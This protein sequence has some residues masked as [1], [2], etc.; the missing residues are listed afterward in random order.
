MIASNTQNTLTIATTDDLSGVVGGELVGVHTFNT[1]TVTG[2]ADVDF[3]EDRVIEA[4]DVAAIIDADGD[5]LS[6]TDEITYGTD[7]FNPDSDGDGI[8]DGLEV[9]LG[10]NPADSASG[11]VSANTI[12]LLVT[13]ATI[14]TDI[15]SQTQPIQLAVVAVVG[16]NSKVYHVDVTN[17]TYPGGA[18]YNSSDT[19]VATSQGDGSFTVVGTGTATLT[20]AFAGYEATSSLTITP[21][22]AVDWSTQTV[23]LTEDRT[24]DS[25]LLNQSTITGQYVLHSLGDLQ[26]QGA[27]V[28]TTINV[29]ELVVDGDLIIDGTTL[30][31]SAVNGINVTG[32]VSLL[33]GAVLTVAE[34][35]SSPAVLHGLELVVGGTLTV[36]AGS[37][38]DLNGRGY[39][40]S[41]WSGPD[42]S[43]NTRRG[44]HG[45][46]RG[47]TSADC[48]YGRYERARYAGSAGNYY[49][50]DNQADGGGVAEITAQSLVLE[51][52]I[53]AN[54][55]ST[56]TRTEGAG[57][58]GGLHVEVDTLSGAGQF[59]V[60]GGGA[61]N[62]SSYP[63]GGGG[64]IS[65][66]VADRSGFSGTYQAATGGSGQPGGAGT[67]YIRDAGQ[68]YGH[69][70]VDN[71]GRTGA[72]GSTPMRVVGR[73][74]ITGAGEVAPGVW[75]LDVSGTPWRATDEALGWGVDG[76]EVDLDASETS[77]PQYEIESNT[78]NT[79]T[80]ATTD[81]LSGVVGS[82]LVGVHT[83]ETLTVAGGADVDFGEDRVVVLDVAG[84]SIGAGSTLRLG[85]VDE[86]T[87]ELGGSGGG[88]L[89]V[90]HNPALSNL[91]LS[92]LGGSTLQFDEP[93]VVDTLSVSSGTVRFN[94]GVEVAGALSLGNAAQVTVLA[95]AAD[96]LVITDGARLTGEAVSVD[97]DISLLNG[98]V[99]TVAE[100]TSSPAV[101]HGLELVVGG[102]LTV[103]AGSVIDLNG[104][105]YPSSHWSGP[106]FSNNTRRGCH[107]GLRGNTS[108]DCSY[109]RYER[110][111]YAGSAGN[112]YNVDNQADGGG[113]AEITAQS[114]VL[115]GV[116]RANGESTWT[117]TEGAG[118]GGGLHVEVDTLSGAGQF[119][120][121]GGG[122]YNSSSY[123]AGGGGR[124][125][126]YVAD[127]SG[128][129][130]TY[131]AATGGS[132]Q[133]GGAGTVYIRDAGQAYGHLVVDNAG[134]TGAS[135]STP[136]RVV[137]RHMITGAGEVAPGVWK[138]DVSG[139][140]WRATDEALG[141]GVDGI[142]VDLDASETSSPQYE[143]ESNTANT[144]TIATTDDLS[145]VVGGELVGV[146]TFETLTV[147]GGADVDFG[148]DRVVV[149]DVAG[150]SI[151]AGSTLRLGEVDQATLE[152][153]GSGGGTLQ[154]RHNPA[155]SNL[156][157]SSL[158]GSTLQ[159]DE[160][161]VVDTL[162][163]SSGTVRF[164]AGVEVAGALSLG[165][166]AQVTALALAAD[167]LVITDG[168]RL[169][170][171]A[172]SV[173]TDV[174]LLNGAVLTV[175]EATSS[176]AVLHGLELVVGGTLTVD[177]GSVID[178]N[179]RG[180]PSSHWSGPDFSNNTRRGCHGGL[181]G[182]TSA[183]CSYGRY[184]RARYAGS[185]G[186]Y[187]NVDNQA[188][189]GGVA[190]ITAQSLV[191]EGV[192][193]A[194]GEST[195]TRTEGAGAGGGLHVEVDTLSGAGQFA[196]RGG[197]AY[198]SSSYPAGGGGRI[199]VY[200]AD[201]SGFSG[202]YQ[203]ATGGSGQPGGAGT[204]YIRD[205]GQAYGHL[206]VDNAGRTGASGSTPM[207]VVG[208]HMI[209]G[210]GEVAPG[211]WKLDVSGT[212]W[213][214]TDEA[215]GWGVDGIEVDL[216]ASETSSPQYEIESNTAN[217]LTIA[218]TDDLSGVVG[219]ELVGVHTFE[220]LTVAGGADMDFGED[221][222][223]VL[224]V[225]GSSIGAGST[226]RLGE[227]DQATLELGGSGGGTLQV[228]HNPALSNLNLSSLGGSTLQFDEPVVVDTLSVSSGTVRF[229]AG[230]EVA[231][232]L[233]L[234]NA[235]QV[236]AL[237]LAADSLVITDGARL[238]GE[239]VSVDT[240]VS[241]LNGAVLTVAEAT[242]SPA[243][244]HGL[245][246]VVGG[247]LTVDAGS[248][249][250]LNG[251]GYPS[252]H[253]SGPDF[254]NNTRRGCH[255]G[256][257][258]NTSAD[259]SYGRYERARYAG[260][261]GNYYNV[262]NQAD[263]GGVAEITAQSLVLEG[264]IRANGES[265]WTRTE[266]AGAGGGLHV[267]VDTLSGA[268]QFAVRGGG[269]YNSSS[270]PAGGGGRISVYVADRSG[271]S[272]TYQAATGGSG[273]PGGA[274]TVYIRDAGQAYG[275]LVVDNAGRTGAS[276]STPMRVVGRHMITGAGEVAPGVWKLDVSGTPWRATDE[277][278][279]W[280]VDGI[281]V[282]LDASETSSPQYEIESNTANTLTIATTD[283]LSGVVGSELVGVHTFETLTVAGGADVDFGEDRVVQLH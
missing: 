226:L 85:E 7:P 230:V 109:G 159:F 243:V 168:A 267:E 262:D 250:D 79:L 245:E 204:V 126:V 219:S 118:A 69:L 143:I 64:R 166:A 10:T 43:N 111:R 13:P 198:N 56:W 92:G 280:G 6:D 68:A 138:L 232:A 277:A 104:R 122:A 101:L 24:I 192:I 102:T 132:G 283:D 259:C 253:W 117:R 194:N 27:G 34:A 108:A 129:S 176:P 134:R 112:Y 145:G 14:T 130:G 136:M 244:L 242:S 110:A 196:V 5:E 51:G 39:P 191:L 251:R 164:N 228:R 184:E 133:P 57:A 212:P 223:V 73:H 144:L 82:E 41:H 182:N 93:V 186:N 36:D 161:V 263:G 150:S 160:P 76:I 22:P 124:I 257:R 32:N 87:L 265:T 153:G 18:T 152:L 208:R 221:R 183:D 205:A 12:A 107:G 48:S 128:F 282:D 225:A 38:I 158:G 180:Y 177:A 17:T 210:A 185:A 163:V 83:F 28:T 26:V 215:L 197:G 220:T 119:A 203:A 52:V 137:G 255:G 11:D 120:V 75:K 206:V 209:T 70:V 272:G 269:A 25:A 246:L 254:S 50:V 9:V 49:N 188:D 275:H 167:S 98:A 281:E 77:S 123:P 62:S 234:G 4:G 121:R 131:Q 187:Y 235:A 96:S 227:V 156:N 179:G 202:T 63:A 115:E 149:L 264:V 95:L 15:Y 46:L 239:A 229:N 157:L 74:M 16:V 146:H 256:L 114:L 2:G 3:G 271:F 1:L 59:A 20:A 147:A 237:A 99:L 84:S 279:G 169:T 217:T 190:E 40:S 61:Y 189:G 155:L 252:S 47:N 268:G 213:R 236:T 151:G 80:I 97:T 94:A 231:G 238:T 276:G 274:G 55:E 278:L 200:V 165:N 181:R 81:D 247:T 249:I 21:P 240:D 193:R 8:P 148:E 35:T 91:D 66:Y 266:G 154:V 86:A 222:V 174:S 178:L 172:V 88:T 140:P 71:A 42:F 171:E 53:R 199:S 45:G 125:S 162:S 116:I 141:W 201:R 233:S 270:Y 170:G 65:V 195:W 175:A 60:R 211:V 103:D 173:D 261:A 258:G 37:V 224:D 78:A 142:E 216:D 29:Q 58:G 248:V 207:R 90:R 218:T 72:S 23:D 260:S 89:Q 127:R 139:T 135:G 31:I 54:G 241:L 44:C 214:A 106:D 30:V 33:N 67:V 273:Q 105:G 19:S 100:A 113:V